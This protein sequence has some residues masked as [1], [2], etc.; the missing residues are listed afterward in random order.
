MS[1]SSLEG[2]STGQATCVFCGELEQVGVAD[3]WADG[4]FQLACCCETMHDTV[5]CEMADD[6]V[7]ARALL[8]HAGVEAL[9]GHRLRRVADDGGCTML[10]DYQ[11]ELRPV[12]FRVARAFVA[13]HHQH[14]GPPVTWRFG[15]AINNG[16]NHLGVVMVGNLVARALNG[17]GVLEVNRLCIRRDVPRALAWNAASM[18]YGWAAREAGRRG[19]TRIITYTRAD[20]EGTSLR[21]AGWNPEA[22]VRGRGWHGQ[23][24]N[25]SN[26]NSWIDKVRWG[27]SLRPVNAR[28]GKDPGHVHPRRPGAR[29]L[30]AALFGGPGA[31]DHLV[32]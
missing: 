4:T 24:R 7:W 1:A 10:L 9:T 6:P 18:L 13:R 28:Q 8:R 5:V 23:D 14:C 11:L 20:E 26:T 19:W 21:A 15:V 2:N 16:F 22:S 3:V 27:K 32:L 30:D 29:P 17:R 31:A 12:T 25:R